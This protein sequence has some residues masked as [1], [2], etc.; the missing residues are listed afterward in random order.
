MRVTLILADYAQAAEGKLNI[1]GGGWTITGPIPS[2]SAIGLIV[3]VPWDQA[4]TKHRFLIELLDS[5]GQPVMVDTPEG[6]RPLQ[7]GGEFEVGRPPG[8]KRGTPLSFTTAFNLPPQPLEPGS[9]FEWKLAINGETR[10]DWRLPF[11]TRATDERP[12]GSAPY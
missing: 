4:N 2:P 12:P 1:I 8:I 9:R 5:D 3:D 6:E 7:I 11:S 10:D